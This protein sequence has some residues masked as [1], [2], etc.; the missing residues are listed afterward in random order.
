[1]SS[2]KQ[3]KKRRKPNLLLRQNFVIKVNRI[4]LAKHARKQKEEEEVEKTGKKSRIFFFSC[5]EQVLFR[6][7]RQVLLVV[8]QTRNIALLSITI[9]ST[10]AFVSAIAAADAVKCMCVCVCARY[11]LPYLLLYADCHQL[12]QFF[13]FPLCSFYIQSLCA[14]TSQKKEGKKREEVLL[15]LL[16]SFFIFSRFL[17]TT[18]LPIFICSVFV[19]ECEY[20]KTEFVQKN[21]RY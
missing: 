21:I 2:Q 9:T 14:V 15:H 12:F 5:S 13:F 6:A 19:V 1:M 3:K 4:K 18:L 8:F 16:F 20:L 11:I 10:T 17:L 7:N